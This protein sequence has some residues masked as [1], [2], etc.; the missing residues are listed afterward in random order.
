VARAAIGEVELEYE[1]HGHGVPLVLVMGIGA[2]MVFWDAGLIDRFVDAGFQVVVFDHRDVGLSTRLDH[3]PVPKPGPVM[4]RSLFGLTVAA[5]YTLSDMAGDV[6]GL[7]DHLAID[8]AH[9]V[10]VSMGGMIAQHLSIEHA[11]RLRTITSIMSTTGQRPLRPA[12]Q[13]RPRALRA[14]FA[15]LPRS[16]DQA[17]DNV[18]TLFRAIG[19]VGGGPLAPADEARVRDLGRRAFERGA[20]PRGFLRHFAAIAASGDRTERLRA[21]RTP[22]LVIHGAH[23]P[24]IR[25]AAGRAT[26]RAI[27]G[28]RY[29][30]LPDMAHFM[31]SARWDDIVG[32]IAAH[33]RPR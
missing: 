28:A 6:V 13:P 18:A 14:L 20:A 33:A 5:P 30:E 17:A 4:V 3:L 26:A 11:R 8:R 32:A 22:A 31:P 1:V 24:L 25:V 27:P 29:L 23:D 21:V 9:V 16:A 19:A 15:P 7:L 10:G 12:L 2:Q